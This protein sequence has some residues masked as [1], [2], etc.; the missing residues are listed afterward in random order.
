MSDARE[1]P[2]QVTDLIELAKRYLRQ[3]TVDPLKSIGRSVARALVAVLLLGVG[4]VLL[5]LGLHGFVGDLLPEGSWNAAGAALITA[6]V[7]LA[8]AALV[9]GRLRTGDE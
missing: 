6:V 2:Q 3:E 7:S 5:A 8:A 9:A 1:L 4:S